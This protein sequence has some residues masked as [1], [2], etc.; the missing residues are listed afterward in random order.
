M[1][2]YYYN[3]SVEDSYWNAHPS[4]ADE[5]IQNQLLYFDTKDYGGT[6]EQTIADLYLRWDGMPDT[7]Q[8]YERDPKR[9]FSSKPRRRPTAFSIFQMPAD[10]EGLTENTVFTLT[11]EITAGA[12][13]GTRTFL[14]TFVPRSGCNAIK[15]DN[16]WE[17]AGEVWTTYRADTPDATTRSVYFNNAVTAFGKVQVVFGK[18]ENGKIEWMNGEAVLDASWAEGRRANNNVD[19]STYSSWG[20]GWLNMSQ[21]DGNQIGEHTIP[22][23]VWG[24][25]DVPAEYTHVMFRGALDANADDNNKNY[26]QRTKVIS[27]FRRR[28]RSTRPIPTPVSLPTGIWTKARQEVPT[29]MPNPATP[30]SWTA[31][32]AR[33]W[34]STAWGTAAPRCLR[35]NSPPRTI[36]TMPP[37]PSMTTIPCGSSRGT[38]LRRLR[39]VMTT[40]NRACC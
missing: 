7:Y 13:I 25:T 28:W 19:K 9:A 2:A 37:P 18:K 1:D 36:P 21:M 6:E 11:Y 4:N 39:A 17:D 34:K 22:A 10:R 27:G 30:I 31:S 20:K 38:P 8:S 3:T 15:M 24:F 29:T 14:F 40:T 16:L 12:H 33:R 35:G 32:G 26:I 5:G 23:N